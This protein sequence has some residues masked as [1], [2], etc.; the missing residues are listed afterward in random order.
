MSRYQ[1]E[2][3][4]KHL[5]PQRGTQWP[6]GATS[7]ALRRA[8][9]GRL[10]VPPGLPGRKEHVVLAIKPRAWML[11]LLAMLLL[12]SYAAAPAMAERGPFCWHREIGNQTKGEKVKAQLPEPFGGQGKN[13]VLTGK[14]G[15]T[16]FK[17]EAP[18]V[19][20]KGII[21]NNSFQCQLK[22]EIHFQSLTLIEPKIA[23]CTITV[24]ASDNTFAADGD[25]EWKY[26]GNTKELTEQPQ[27]VQKPDLMIW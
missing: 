3:N 27:Q 12:G 8:F 22:V 11:G 1:R 26:E 13:Q 16:T 25:W 7:S 6:S 19:Q 9:G 17:I 24:G 21:Y 10:I 14:E 15:G 4:A 18:I 23:G 20:I 2:I 5:G